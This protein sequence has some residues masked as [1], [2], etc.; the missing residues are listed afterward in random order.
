MDLAGNGYCKSLRST[1]IYILQTSESRGSLSWT[2][3][4]TQA[5][6]MTVH[7]QSRLLHILISSQLCMNQYRQPNDRQTSQPEPCS[8][9]SLVKHKNT[10]ISISKSLLS[11]TF[12]YNPIHHGNRSISHLPHSL[13]QKHHST[14]SRMPPPN[15][16]PAS[17]RIT[18]PLQIPTIDAVPSHMSHSTFHHA[19]TDSQQAH[20]HRQRYAKWLKQSI[21]QARLYIK[22]CIQISSSDRLGLDSLRGAL[23][24]SLILVCN[25]NACYAVV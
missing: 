2:S 15:G 24:Q 5:L 9:R 17:S 14:T 10:L 21:S 18:L 25:I 13:S 12:L 23:E 11:I 6:E 22:S 20:D 1:E 16:Q 3:S 4:S 8:S 7:F 19:K